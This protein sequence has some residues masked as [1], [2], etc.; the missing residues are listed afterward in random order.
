MAEFETVNPTFWTEKLTP[1]SII[2]VKIPEDSFLIITNICFGDLP[3]NPKN[4]PNRIISI[5]QNEYLM[6]TLV[7]GSIEHKQVNIS[8][9][10]ENKMKLRLDG[11]YPVYITGIIVT[12]EE[13]EE[14]ALFAEEEE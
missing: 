8:V 5:D 3:E 4:S 7:P 9:S 12:L 14:F 6:C 2:D 13:E 11:E 10:P 1:N